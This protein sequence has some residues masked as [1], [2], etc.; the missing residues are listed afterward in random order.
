MEQEFIRHMSVGHVMERVY[1][2]MNV[3]FAM[4]KV[5]IHFK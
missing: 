1:I 5:F 2:K 4:V 3:D